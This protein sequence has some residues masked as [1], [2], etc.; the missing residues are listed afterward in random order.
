[1]T[2]VGIMN[3]RERMKDGKEQRRRKGETWQ[4]NTGNLGLE[5]W[6][7]FRRRRTT[8][9][10]QILNIVH[11]GI[12]MYSTHKIGQFPREKKQSSSLAI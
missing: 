12:P 11:S 10:A 7:F 5:I 6:L 1:M 2:K 4:L 9:R 8:D 3:D